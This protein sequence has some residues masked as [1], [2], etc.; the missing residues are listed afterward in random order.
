M[1]TVTRTSQTRAKVRANEREKILD[2]YINVSGMLPQQ[3]CEDIKSYANTVMW[4]LEPELPGVL[5]PILV[6]EEIGDVWTIKIIP[7]QKTIRSFGGI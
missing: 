1:T 4:W 3:Q 6:E 2:W 7:R 5:N